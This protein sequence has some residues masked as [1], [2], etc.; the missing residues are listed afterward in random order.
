MSDKQQ[1]TQGG[2]NQPDFFSAKNQWIERY[3]SYIAQAKNWRLAAFVAFGVAGVAVCSNV[4]LAS[5]TKIV[6]YVVQVDDFGNSV[7]VAQEIQS[8]ALN[9]PVITHVISHWVVEARERIYDPQAENIA[10][11]DTYNYVTKDV[12]PI[13]SQYYQT[14]NPLSAKNDGDVTVTINTC[15]PM[16]QISEKGGTYQVT[17]TEKTYDPNA[18]S[19]ESVQNYSAIISYVI[20]KNVPA[21]QL[22]NNPFGVYITSFQWQKT[23]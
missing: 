14:N 8:G 10:A 16:G 5:Q 1:K 13:L 19:L 6:P 23:L 12:A 2:A 3:G 9:Q 15:L 7:H 11:R 22:I 20:D 18:N 4:W 21:A 17:W